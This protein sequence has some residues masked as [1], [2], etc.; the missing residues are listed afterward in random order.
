MSEF[1]FCLLRRLEVE[2]HHLLGSDASEWEDRPKVIDE[3]VEDFDPRV[4][5]RRQERRP[6][7]WALL[8]HLGLGQ[9][10]SAA[11]APYWGVELAVNKLARY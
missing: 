4:T 6:A 1:G 3:F 8:I 7:L 11:K 10:S 5:D 9:R 2:Q